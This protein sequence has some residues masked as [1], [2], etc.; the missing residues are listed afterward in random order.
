MAVSADNQA[1]AAYVISGGRRRETVYTRVCKRNYNSK[2]VC[3]CVR[4]V[5][6]K[7]FVSETR[8]ENTGMGCGRRGWGK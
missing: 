3:V 7:T 2:C 5:S 1:A 8:I 6:E 4:C